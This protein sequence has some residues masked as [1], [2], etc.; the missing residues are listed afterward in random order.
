MAISRDDVERVSLLA[1]L[2]LSPDEVQR[3]T[4][5][6]TAIVGYIDQLSQLDTINVEP[7]AHAVPLSNVFAEDI[8]QPSLPRE[9]ALASAPKHDEEC[10]LVPPVLG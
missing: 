6:L 8:V 5:Q 3:M 7:M 2:K 1:R 9:A 10:Y 4:T